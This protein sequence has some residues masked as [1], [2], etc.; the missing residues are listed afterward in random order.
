MNVQ[1]NLNRNR[2]YLTSYV[3]LF[4]LA[5]TL[6]YTWLFPLIGRLK[7]NQVLFE[8]LWLGGRIFIW[9]VPVWLILQN[10][11]LIAPCSYLKLRFNQM[12]GLAWGL[13]IGFIYIACLLLKDYFL[14]DR[15]VNFN[16]GIH[17]WLGGLLI[18][19]I[20]EIPF[21][22]FL[23]QKIEEHMGFW[24]ANLIS[25][26]L[27]TVHHYPKWIYQGADGILLNSIIVLIVGLVLGLVFKKSKSL[28]SV[29]I[30]HSIYDLANWIIIGGVGA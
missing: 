15:S 9:I 12:K 2:R 27:F 22:G 10:T 13:V 6:W 7:G 14:G 25:S 17:Y 8:S 1:F 28:W 3:S 26:F 30:L 4:L 23:L 18:G 29:V 16:I 11:D 19:L 21:R 24:K 20:E 5:V